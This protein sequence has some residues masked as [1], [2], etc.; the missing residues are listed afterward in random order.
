MF[1]RNKFF[2]VVFVLFIQLNAFGQ[3]T[4]VT[5]TGFNEDVIAEGGPSSLSTTSNYVDAA[6]SN[7]VMYSNAFRT[8]AGISGGGLPDNGVITNGGMTFQL[9]AYTN[10]NALFVF[11]NQTGSLDLAAPTSFAKLRILC[12]ATEANVSPATALLNISLTFT[13]GTTVPYINNY[14]LADWFNGTSNVVITGYGRCSRV[15][16]APWGAEGFPSNPNMYYVEITLACADIQKQLQRITFSNVTTAGSNAPFPNEVILAVSGVPYSQSVLPTIVP[17]DC[18][19]PNGS[20]S[21][22]ITGSSSPYTYSWN[23]TPIQT[24]STAT[25]LAPGNYSCTITDAS[26]CTTIYNGTVPLNNNAVMNAMANP[27]A[28]CPNA[29]VQLTANVT[30]GSLSTYTWTP[31]NLSGQ[32]VSVSPAITTTYTVNASNSLGCTATSQVTVTVNAIPAEPVVNN[33]TICSGTTATLQIQSPQTGFTYNWYDAL[34]GGILLTT[35]ITYTTPV[36][37]SSATYYVDAVNAS[38]C[39]SVTRTPV[40]VTVTNLPSAPAANNVTICSG[41][42]ATLSVINPQTGYTYNWYNVM[43][44]GTILASGNTYTVNN[45]SSNATYYVNAVT[46]GGCISSTRTPVTINLLV[47]LAQPDVMLTNTTFTSLSFA[48]TSVPGAIGYEVTIDGGATFQM[49]SSGSTGTSHTISGLTGNQTIVF[50]VRA[51]GQQACENS[52]LSVAVS[53]T[54]LSTKEIFVPNVFTPNGDGKNDILYVY[55]NYI[56]SIKFLIFNQW[57]ELIFQ[58][59]NINT[60]WNGMYKGRM[61]PMGVYVYALKVVLQDGTVINKKG[62]INLIK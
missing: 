60:G 44:G 20:I 14:A 50:Q 59:D 32:V 16:S 24:S 19:G 29:S 35:G 33:V 31:G 61:Q 5:V 6:T 48:W 51:L 23:T 2:I 42:N 8:F 37:T 36:L 11:R 12:F 45:V 26:G 7:K 47:A 30:T 18:S 46:P 38:N 52:A 53:G 17:C 39:S 21:L 49:P 22:N 56:A 9:A 58:S 62:S 15:A 27:A 28:V 34:S 13:D 41:T 3:Y 40:N 57:G 54:T 25:N 10:N 43:T 55:G 1:I 4:P